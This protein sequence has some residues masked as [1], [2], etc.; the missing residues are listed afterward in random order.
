[1]SAN[2]LAIPMMDGKAPASALHPHEAPEWSPRPRVSIVM[3][4]YNGAPFILDA[5]ASASR[6]T[7]RDLEIIVV[8]DGSTDNSVELVT[9]YAA[10]DPRVALLH[11]LG[12][13]GP[14]AA[15]N[16]ALDVARGC[17]IAV[18]DSDDIM[19]PSRLEILLDSAEATG[20]DIVADNQIVFDD[21]RLMP[22]HPL[23]TRRQIPGG[24]VL[25]A[26]YINSN[27]FFSRGAPLGYLKPVFS[28]V[29][30]AQ[31]GCRYDPGLRIAEDYDLVLRLLLA[32]AHFRISPHLTYFYRRHHHSVSHRLS[33]CTLQPMLDADDRLR[34]AQPAETRPP[35]IRAAL[36]RRRST[37]RR[38]IDFEG[39]VATLKERR[40][41]SATLLCLSRP[42]VAA[43]LVIPLQD[44]LR[45]VLRRDSRMQP[46]VPISGRRAALLSR[47]RI[48]GATNGSSAYLLGIC[49][50]LRRNGYEIDLISPSP[51]MFGRW[52]VLR[53][54]P[55]MDVFSSIRIRGSWRV[56]RLIVA[57]DPRIAL[58][59]AG[60][61][62]DRLLRRLRIEITPLGQK[63]PHAIAVPLTDADRLFISS[64]PRDATLIITDYAFLN[65]AIPFVLQPCVP[66]V[67]VMHDFFSD[68][69]TRRAVIHLDPQT[70]AMLLAK[71]DAVLAIQSE[72]ADKIRRLLPGTPV[73]LAPMAVQPVAAPRPG[74]SGSLLFV[75]S[76]TLPNLDGIRWF[77]DEAW[78]AILQQFPLARLR[79]AGSCCGGLSGAM[80]GVTLLG[81]VDDLDAAYREAGIVISPLRLGS[82]LKIKLIEA[83]GHGKAIIATGTTLQGVGDLVSGAVI[84]ADTAEAFVAAAAGLL[85]NQAARASLGE[86]ALEIAQ[87]YFSPET[88]YRGLLDFADSTGRWVGRHASPP[89]PDPG[90]QT[91][92]KIKSKDAAS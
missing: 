25:V 41:I 33:I 42:G 88:C 75:G 31:A 44:R 66:S 17:W 72:E 19:H 71:A 62:A 26:D 70:E 57:R 59:A 48:V 4:N 5:L 27:T 35:E 89:P 63:A 22:S 15:R 45:R 68:Q 90:D 76:N 52:P 77:L 67:V 61:I 87:R 16:L 30:L 21:A 84:Q 51:A 32:G 13:G 34:A 24:P 65:E 47:Q 73:I 9:Q 78:P 12:N 2:L 40:W 46:V 18:L 36:D 55:V 11:T 69:D 91:K 23:L 3:A 92:A 83:L 37:I 28:S 39:L 86:A 82:G 54:D 56:G 58:R 81:R 85:L 79:I 80:P 29:F 38:A 7:I 50:Y 20:A 60:A 49:T 64:T 53:L 74:E 14:A 6:Q 8:D 1:M 10:G 43:L